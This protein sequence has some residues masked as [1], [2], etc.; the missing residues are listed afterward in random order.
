VLSWIHSPWQSNPG[1]RDDD[2][3]MTTTGKDY[4]LFNSVVTLQPLMPSSSHLPE[5]SLLMEVMWG[6]MNWMVLD[7]VGCPFESLFTVKM[8]KTQRVTSSALKSDLAHEPIFHSCSPS[9]HVPGMSGSELWTSATNPHEWFTVA[10][11]A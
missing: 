11:G 3:L 1:S 7:V 8:S 5:P 9:R 6:L 2:H 10:Q 4:E